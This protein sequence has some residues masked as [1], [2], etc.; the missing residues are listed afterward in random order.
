VKQLIRSLTVVVTFLAAFNIPP[1]R[2]AASAQQPPVTSAVELRPGVVIDAQRRVMYVMNVKGGVD[3]V[4]LN[5]GELVWHSDEAARPVASN[6]QSLIAQSEPAK[7]GTREAAPATNELLVRVLDVRTGRRRFAIAHALPPGIRAN[8]VGTAEGTFTVRALTTPTDATL[9]WE[10]DEAPL[11]GVRPGALDVDAAPADRRAPPEAAAARAPTA[12][13]ALRID[14]ASGKVAPLASAGP[15]ALSQT[16]QRRLDVAAAERVASVTGDQFLSSDG[17]HVLASERIADDSIWDKYQ[18]T[19]IERSS[20]RRVGSLRDY[21]SHA[22]FM[23]VGTTIYYE[24][25]PVE[26]RTGGGVI[27]EPLRI[28]AVDLV[29]GAQLWIRDV[30]DTTYRGPFPS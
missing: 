1:S 5:R 28:R 4:G 2:S 25:G 12:S 20:G 23:V 30:R 21:R 7:A 26:R 6:T 9:A 27:Q 3:A 19:I 17:R 14:L 16:Q 15:L 18:W 29:K 11:Q 8:V 24:T 10:Y 22:P 13:G